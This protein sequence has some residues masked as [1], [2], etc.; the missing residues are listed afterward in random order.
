MTP[1]FLLNSTIDL[2]SGVK[3]FNEEI[4][5]YFI[6]SSLRIPFTGK[7]SSAS[8]L[9]NVIVPVLSKII[10]LI[11]PQVSTALP[12]IAMT[13]NLFTLSIPA[14]PMAESNPPIVV[15]I[16]QTSKAISV[17]KGR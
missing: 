3:S 5:E 6:I 1:N 2:P 4:A 12:D 13:L 15:G 17:D 11:S 8:L 14:I 10:V 7:N 16:K 9:P